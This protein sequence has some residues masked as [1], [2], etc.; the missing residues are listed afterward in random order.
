MAMV[1]QCAQ[2]H[3]ARRRGRRAAGRL[4]V[5]RVLP[6]ICRCPSSAV[7]GSRES[8][9]G[10][11]PL[12]SGTASTGTRWPG[13]G[14][15]GQLADASAD[16]S[17]KVST[18]QGGRSSATGLGSSGR[19]RW[20][21]LACRSRRP[22]PAGRSGLPSRCR[23]STAAGKP[24]S[25]A[26]LPIVW[27]SVP[28]RSRPPWSRNAEVTGVSQRAATGEQHPGQRGLHAG[29]VPLQTVGDGEQP[30]ASACAHSRCYP[31]PGRSRTRMPARTALTY[32]RVTFRFTALPQ[33]PKTGSSFLRAVRPVP[34]GRR[35][36][37]QN[38]RSPRL[39]SR[40][41][42]KHRTQASRTMNAEPAQAA[43]DH[44]D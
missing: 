21:S 17:R 5:P 31:G 25:Q 39:P 12:H 43:A 15:G 22:I 38:V 41:D 28:G 18:F 26:R 16:T 29:G 30:A 14:W 42:R 24:A 19:S 44:V 36:N 2:A 37:P 13:S 20:R 23:A 32:R 9:C 4:A 27:S 3:R 8:A 40:R 6:L 7:S 35:S 33:K 34:C 11:G 1:R 10:A